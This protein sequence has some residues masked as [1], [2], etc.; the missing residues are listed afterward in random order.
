VVEIDGGII[1]EILGARRLDQRR[2]G[3]LQSGATLD[4]QL[5]DHLAV[6]FNGPLERKL[7]HAAKARKGRWV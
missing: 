1:D 5:T 3:R 6:R 2:R 4:A 7:V